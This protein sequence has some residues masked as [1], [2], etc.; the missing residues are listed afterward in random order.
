LEFTVR[1]G[2]TVVFV[3]QLARRHAAPAT[4]VNRMTFDISLNG[5]SI[6]PMRCVASDNFRGDRK[7]FIRQL[8]FSQALVAGNVL[9]GGAFPRLDVDSS[10]SVSEAATD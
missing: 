9:P 8:R 1:A 7:N 4:I 10:T 2:A 6:T 3:A 5:R